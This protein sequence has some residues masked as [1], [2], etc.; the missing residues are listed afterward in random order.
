[1]RRTKIICTLGPAQTSQEDVQLLKDAGMNVARLNCSHGTW[2]ER[3]QLAEWVRAC[4]GSP[5][6][7]L[8]DLQGPKFRIGQMPDQGLEIHRGETVEFGGEGASIP[9]ADK[10]V[11]D[12]IEIGDHILLGDGEIE[13]VVSSCS[14]GVWT[15]E[16]K[17]GGIV[18]SR[19]GITVV[20][21]SFDAPSLTPKDVQDIEQAIAMGADFIALSYVRRSADMRLLRR[22]LEQKGASDDMKLVAKIETREALGDIDGIIKAS[23]VVMVARGDLGLQMNLD[24]VPIAQKEIIALCGKAGKPVITATQMLESMMT[25]ARPTRAEASDI[26]NAILDGTD[27]LMLSGETAAG[28][29]PVEAV[30]VMARVA[31]KAEAFLDPVGPVRVM[32]GKRDG[33][34]IL[35][36]HGID[37]ALRADG[38]QPVGQHGD[39][40]VVGPDAAVLARSA[41]GQRVLRCPQAIDLK[42]ADRVDP[43]VGRDAH[44]CRPGSAEHGRV[45][46]AGLGDALGLIA[47]GIDQTLFGQSAQATREP[48]AVL[49]EQIRAELVDDDR[50]DEC[51]GTPTISLDL[52]R[53]DGRSP[54]AEEKAGAGDQACHGTPYS[55]SSRP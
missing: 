18:R 41:V 6:G 28:R 8:V 22:V 30:N 14:H 29:Y 7:V 34:A 16:V 42:S 33:P 5:T 25:L 4:K 47:V 40:D 35:A 43:F 49:V 27:A 17:S 21:R 1:M 51:G 52:S 23:D 44:R 53:S 15:A 2:A 39:A 50:H 12:A 11:L 10:E 54:K 13:M 36:R 48:A 3:I 45:A 24:D 55:S 31:E 20:G 9:I 37:A 32:A 38:F 26:A 19:R 46:W